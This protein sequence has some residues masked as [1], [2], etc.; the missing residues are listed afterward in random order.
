MSIFKLPG[1]TTAQRTPLVLGER[2]LVYDTDLNLVYQGNGVTAGGVAV[3]AGGGSGANLSY[4]ASTRVVASDT[5][6]DATLTLVDG[7]NAG[8]MTSADFVKLGSVA[9][10]ATANA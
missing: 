4:T 8:L 3:G 6:T 7:A 2:E 10:G 5:G 9:S 1:I